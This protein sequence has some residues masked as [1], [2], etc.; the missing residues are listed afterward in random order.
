MR[1]RIGQVMGHLVGMGRQAAFQI[2]VSLIATATV[3]YVTGDRAR[4]EAPQSAA[5]AAA[6]S[7]VPFEPQPIAGLLRASFTADGIRTRP[8][9]PTEFGALFGPAPGKPHVELTS[10]EWP[11]R[12]EPAARQLDKPAPKGAAKTLVAYQGGVARPARH[13]TVAEPVL[14]PARPASFASL[15]ADAAP[16]PAAGGPAGEDSGVRL[17]G[18]RLPGFVPSGREVVKTVASLGE[19]VTGLFDGMR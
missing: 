4:T 6:A 5:T 3:A 11:S 12:S 9:Y 7:S 15:V 2:T 1:E 14:P 8:G 10:L 16:A 18:M 17:L 13:A 19:S